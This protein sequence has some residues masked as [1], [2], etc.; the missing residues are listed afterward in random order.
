MNSGFLFAIASMVFLGASTFFYKKSSDAF[1]PTNSTFYYYLYS[2]ILASILWLFFREREPIAQNAHIWSILLSI[3]LFLSVWS[4]NF[5]VKSLDLS[6]AST[7]RSLFFLVPVLVAPF[8][9]GER[10]SPREI[11][12]VLFAVVA[13]VLFGTQ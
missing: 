11:V 2:L 8:I 3:T 1:G 12:A 9:F 10:L 6:V 5:A 13:V 4:F 7:I